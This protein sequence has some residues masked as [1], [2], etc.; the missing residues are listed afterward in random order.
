MFTAEERD[1]LKNH[2]VEFARNDPRIVAGALVGSLTGDRADRWSDVDLTFAVKDDTPISELLDE[3]SAHL[4]NDF[5]AIQLFDLLVDPIVYRVYLLPRGLQLDVS[6]SPASRFRATSERFQLLFG[7][8]DDSFESPS[9]PKD[10]LGWALMWA[11]SAR[12][13][14]ERDR[15][16]LA[17]HCVTSFRNYAMSYACQRRNLTASYGKGFD[18]LPPDLLESYEKM[19]V[20]SLDRNE[21]LRAFEAGIA[22]LL[23]DLKA[24]G[25]LNGALE[26]R[27]QELT[28]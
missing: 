15:P 4:A 22:A 18:Q 5:E 12:V 2:V 3:W 14:I 10:L 13:Y 20:R 6:M 7:T 27:I 25:S 19:F 16:W 17:E 23:E 9:P 24:T 11:R 1:R 26:A 21:L 28:E 8:A